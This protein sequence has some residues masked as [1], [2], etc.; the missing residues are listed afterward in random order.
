METQSPLAF[1]EVNRIPLRAA[2]PPGPER[3]ARPGRPVEPRPP[4]PAAYLLLGPAELLLHLLGEEAGGAA[5]PA[6]GHPASSPGAAGPG[7]E[8]CGFLWAPEE[9]ARFPAC[10]ASGRA[11][12]PRDAHPAP[13]PPPR[14]HP[15]LPEAA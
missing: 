2:Q 1:P 4:L 8:P 10:L 14:A 3:P 11:G 7:P 13:P 12:G 15:G 9:E 5:R 6:L